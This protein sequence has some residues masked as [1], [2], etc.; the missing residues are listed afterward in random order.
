[1][2]NTKILNIK[3]RSAGIVVYRIPEENIRR[4]FAP[5]EVKRIAYSELEKLTYQPGGRELMA[6]FLQIDN[7][8]VIN[9]LNIYTT[10]EYWMSEQNIIDLIKEGSL[11]Q[12]LDALD[13]APVG[14]M[15]LIKKFSVSLPLTDTRKIEALKEK[16]GFDVIA[17]VEHV[18]E[19][20][21]NDEILTDTKK[22]ENNTA[23][24]KPAAPT[25]RRTNIIYKKDAD[26]PTPKYVVT[27]K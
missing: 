9:D 6:N 26:A 22:T 16:T 27:K 14:A 2:D 12:W 10:P 3:N 13:Y 21:E 17:A 7:S 23:S 5:G 8:Q 19:A 24:V 4:E 1:M 18:K 15:D 25:G 20:S 11:D